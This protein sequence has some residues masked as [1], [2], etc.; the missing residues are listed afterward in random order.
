M[1]IFFFHFPSILNGWIE[2]HENLHVTVY[3]RGV[4]CT[5][6]S[7]YCTYTK[8]IF[9]RLCMSF[10]CPH[11]IRQPNKRWTNIIIMCM[12]LFFFFHVSFFLVDF[13]QHSTPLL[14]E[15]RFHRSYWFSITNV[16]N[17]V[18][19]MSIQFIIILLYKKIHKTRC[20]SLF[21]G[22]EKKKN[23]NVYLL[24]FQM[25]ASNILPSP[26]IVCAREKSMCVWN[27]Y[28]RQEKQPN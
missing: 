10:T 8:P 27:Q 1:I 14:V 13:S 3:I 12:F 7:A 15:P 26:T 24:K 20:R 6:H 22:E 5:R 23:P 11:N 16:A 25:S 4:H 9:F 18:R 2:V 28:E 17:T 21:D 19:S